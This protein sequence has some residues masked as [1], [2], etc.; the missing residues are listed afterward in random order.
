LKLLAKYSRLNLAAT[1]LTF[2]VGSCGL[3]LLLNYIL[4]KEV[5]ERLQAEQQEIQAYL[6]AHHV[7]PDIVLTKDLSTTYQQTTSGGNTEYK[8]LKAGKTGKTEPVR[9]ITF[10]VAA[11]DNYFIVSVSTPL[12]ETEALLQVIICVT[13]AM[14]G[15]LL[16]IGFLINRIVIRRI[17]KP[18][19]ETIEKVEAYTIADQNSLK[20][21]N[22][23]ID[24]FA[25][26]NETI[27]EMVVR[28]QKDYSSLKDFTSQ[29]AH[30]MQTPLAIIRTRLD[31]LLQNEAVLEQNGQHISDIE[32][33]VHRLSKLHQ[34]LLLLTK[35]ENRQ[36]LLNEPVRLDKIVEDKCNEYAELTGAMSLQ[37]TLNLQPAPLLFHQHLAEILVSNLLNNAIRYNIPGGSIKVS[38][39][40]N[41]LSISNTSSK[42]HLDPS[43]LFKRFYRDHTSTDGTGLGLSIVKQICDI[44]GYSINYEFSGGRHDFIIK[45]NSRV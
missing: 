23:A 7:L 16:L 25:L 9:Q 3:Y 39:S 30:E 11:A 35:V 33:A 36:F 40:D 22:V 42:E 21:D 34:S 32:K 8:T 1:I 19:Y 4:I 45:F 28:I 44:A 17:W 15:V 37:I 24:E 20:L 27:N 10:T 43:R 18:F 38:L 12:E 6:K 5:D 29:A 41:T 14:I 26:L 2:V 13:I 31:N